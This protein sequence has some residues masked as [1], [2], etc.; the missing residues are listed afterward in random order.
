MNNARPAFLYGCCASWTQHLIL[1]QQNFTRQASLQPQ[2]PWLQTD[3]HTNALANLRNGNWARFT[4]CFPLFT[5][6]PLPL[7]SNKNLPQ[8]CH[9]GCFPTLPLLFSSFFRSFLGMEGSPAHVVKLLTHPWLSWPPHYF[10]HHHHCLNYVAHW[11]PYAQVTS[12]GSRA[13]QDD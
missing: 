10:L 2:V 8:W 13:L 6:A 7:Q 4:P 1:V 11:N 12:L 5:Q 9:W 3:A